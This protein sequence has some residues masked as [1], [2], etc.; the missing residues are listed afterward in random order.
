MS[1]IRLDSRPCVG[2]QYPIM[3]RRIGGGGGVRVPPATFTTTTMPLRLTTTTD[4]NGMI[5]KAFVCE[6]R[7]FN[8]QMWKQGLIQKVE[9]SL[10]SS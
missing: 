4:K 10:F 1:S 7:V 3:F 2:Q 5:I 9:N 6:Y 8:F